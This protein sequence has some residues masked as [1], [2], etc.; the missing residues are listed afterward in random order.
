LKPRATSD[1]RPRPAANLEFAV[2]TPDRTPV[3]IDVTPLIGHR[4]GVGRSVEELLGAL[5]G[6][7]RGPEVVPYALGLRS[8]RHRALLPAGTRLV[9]LPTRALLVSWSY[10]RLPSIDRWVDGAR[11]VHATNFIVPPSRR[12]SLVTVH[13][14]SF[15]LFP[16]TVDAVVARFAAVLR[17]AIGRGVT[18]HV[19]TEFV[20]GE[21]EDIF[22][23]GLRAAGRIA[24]VP[25][26]VP[27]LGPPVPMPAAL[28]ALA[29]VGPYVLA[30]GTLEHRK[31]LAA[32][33][34]AFG[35]VAARQAD[36]RLIVAGRDGNARPL[37]DAAI[38]ALPPAVRT[39]VVLAGAVG[40]GGRRGLL[41]RARLLAYPSLYEGFG[42]P[43][44]EAMALG[45]PVLAA[46][47]GALPEVAGD[48]AELADPRDTDALAAA[49]DRLLGDPGRRDELVARGRARVRAFSWDAA[50][51]G[52]S[53]VYDR[54][55]G[56]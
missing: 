48:A 4:T 11:V 17:R 6:L 49:L 34:A 18:V 54:L 20:A 15:V 45:V 7:E 22:G 56:R 35:A 16:E 28:G 21:V 26:G 53:A 41:E 31:N 14:C 27:A 37:V 38:A 5:H 2:P 52:L 3:A 30:L 25:F 55:A 50:A 1:G 24:I 33:V 32:L 47:A 12:P 36:I 19:T 29:N 44:L 42:F 46:R 51:R 8:G 10:T 39:R 23:P 40:D 43:M 13:D 9:R